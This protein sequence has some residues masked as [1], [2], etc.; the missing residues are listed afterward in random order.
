MTEEETGGGLPP[1]AQLSAVGRVARRGQL[2]LMTAA[3]S[4]N[5]TTIGAARHCYGLL[6]RR[7]AEVHEYRTRKLHM[8]LIVVDDV[9]YIGSANFDMRSLFVNLEL[10]LRIEDSALA[11]QARK[12]IDAI[13]QESE[14]VTRDWIKARGGWITRLRW[15]LSWFVVST[16]DYTVARRLNFGLEIDQS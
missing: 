5:I 8:K 7:G 12:L 1:P 11:A 13:A 6:L 14:P 4:D 2:R 16:L 15:V 9:V 3:L 10:M